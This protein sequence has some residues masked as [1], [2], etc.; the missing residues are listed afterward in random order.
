MTI[1]RLGNI[2]DHKCILS[3]L[4]NLMGLFAAMLDMEQME[5]LQISPLIIQIAKGNLWTYRSHRTKLWIQAM[6]RDMP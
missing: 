1:Q 5:E 2:I 4:I 3:G 6:A